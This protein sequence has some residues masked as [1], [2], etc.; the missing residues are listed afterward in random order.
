MF[1]LGAALRFN[2]VEIRWLA[3]R[4]ASS[5]EACSNEDHPWKLASRICHESDHQDTVSES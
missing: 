5:R 1:F 2:G 3:T 4:A